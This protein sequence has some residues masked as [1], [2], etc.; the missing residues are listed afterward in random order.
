M[1][2]SRFPP[3]VSF[4]LLFEAH[5]SE[6]R[7][8]TTDVQIFEQYFDE[9][10]QAVPPDRPDSYFRDAFRPGQSAFVN[11]VTTPP[12][13]ILGGV[14]RCIDYWDC[15]G[16]K[17]PVSKLS[18]HIP[19][20]LRYRKQWVWLM[21]LVQKPYLEKKQTYLCRGV[22]PHEAL[23]P[24]N[25]LKHSSFFEV[26]ST[27]VAGTGFVLTNE[28]LSDGT[29]LVAIEISASSGLTYPAVNNLWLA[30]GKPY[31]ECSVE[32]AGWTILGFVRQQL[33][34]RHADG[35]RIFTSGDYV[36]LSGLNAMGRLRDITDELTALD[37]YK[38]RKEKSRQSPWPD[39]PRHRAQLESM[40][41]SIC[42]D[43]DYATYRNVVWAILGTGWADAED[44]ARRWCLTAPHRYDEA[45]FGSVCRSFNP[46]LEKRPTLGTVTHLARLGGWCG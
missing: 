36:E 44:I 20:V 22:E 35:V 28:P 43:C 25:W 1:T 46:R 23:S 13:R 42:A 26:G 17:H 41:A 38:P 16:H 33:P 14:A 6:R 7:F 40:L 24:K 2:E 5:P 39:T 8:T 31:L 12:H 3:F 18:N 34:T 29:Y 32:C 10:R 45:S 11:V 19:G 15:E 37:A 21:P 27:E 4:P 9:A 30:L